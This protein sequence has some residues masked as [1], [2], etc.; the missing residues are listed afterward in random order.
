MNNPT[1]QIKAA[2]IHSF[3]ALGDDKETIMDELDMAI[4]QHKEIRDTV[5]HDNI[6]FWGSNFLDAQGVK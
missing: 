3:Y 5:E 4:Y 2:F 6:L 1:T